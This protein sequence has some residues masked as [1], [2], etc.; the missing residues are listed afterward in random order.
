LAN[1]TMLLAFRT[2]QT[3]PNGGRIEYLAVASAPHWSGPYTNLVNAPLVKV[4]A[5]ATWAHR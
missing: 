5:A 3:Q 1:G 2:V 4:R